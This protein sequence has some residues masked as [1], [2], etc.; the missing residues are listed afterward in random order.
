MTEKKYYR[1]VYRIEVLSGEPLGCIDL[2]RLDYEISEGHCSGRFLDTSEEEVT[3]E[4]M[5]HLLLAQNSDPC[6]LLGEDWETKKELERV[7]FAFDTTGGR[8]VELAE[9]IDALQADLEDEGPTNPPDD[10][11]RTCPSCGAHDLS[12]SGY[13]WCCRGE[14]CGETYLNEE[15]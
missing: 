5:E 14:E 8:S 11:K 9:R 15:V 4:H 7:K 1:T 13:A 10:L 3:A 12:W 6:F 2:T